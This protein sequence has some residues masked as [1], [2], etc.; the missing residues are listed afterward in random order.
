MTDEERHLWYDFLSK[1]PIPAKR[2]KNIGNYILDFYIPQAKIA[3]EID[4]VQH[5]EQK[6]A[7]AD[8]LRDITLEGLGITVLR[9]GNVEINRNFAAVVQRIIDTIQEKGVKI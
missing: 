6:H 7:E 8:V 5:A 2:Q 3:I 9:F 1:L 4:G